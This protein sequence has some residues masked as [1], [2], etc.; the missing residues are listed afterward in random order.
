MNYIINSPFICKSVLVN[1]CVVLI[2]VYFYNVVEYYI[3]FTP[4]V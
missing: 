3:N 2:F 4:I 1:L